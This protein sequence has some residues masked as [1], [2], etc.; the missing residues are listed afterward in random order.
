MNPRAMGALAKEERISYIHT[1]HIGTLNYLSIYVP[2]MQGEH[3]RY[4]NLPYFAK[5]K[6]LRQDIGSFLVALINVYV[7]LL[8]GAGFLVL[9]ISNSITQSLREIGYKLKGLTLGGKNEPIVW[10][11]DDEIGILVT[12]YNK[13]IGELEQ[14]AALLA[15]SERESAWREMA[16]QVAHEITNPL[17]P[18][19]LSIQHLQMA[20]QKNDPNLKELT[21]QVT[22]TLIEQIENLTVIASDFSD[23]AQMPKP[24]LKEIKLNDILNAAS[25]LFKN[26]PN[27]SISIET[28][29]A[30]IMINADKNQMISVFNN[31]LKNAV[32]AIPNERKGII[33]ITLKHKDEVALVT[34][35]DNGIGIP[36]IQHNKVF[37]PNFTTKSSGMGLGL[38]ITHKIIQEISGKI[39]FESEPGKGTKFMVEIPISSS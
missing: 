21:K 22:T 9:F 36:E 26:I 15:K 29:S 3:T 6:N 37:V 23:F 17:T 39:S 24:D 11:T 31:L 5:E 38:A 12:E 7:L 33:K 14:S 10:N 2:I 18:M 35:E 34:V 30:D 20:Q 1:E 28:G 4:L 32:Q 13:M 8:V 27:V 19:K 25:G 16:K